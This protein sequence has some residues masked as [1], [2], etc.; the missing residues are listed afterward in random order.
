MNRTKCK[1]C[2]IEMLSLS[3]NSVCKKCFMSDSVDI[4]PRNQFIVDLHEHNRVER[5]ESQFSMDASQRHNVSQF[6]VRDTLSN[7]YPPGPVQVSGINIVKRI[8]SL[9]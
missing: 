3:I 2:G 1:Y 9:E 8:V 5:R 6:I 4:R 7:T